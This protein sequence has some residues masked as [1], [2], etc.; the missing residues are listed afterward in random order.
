MYIC[1]YI[2]TYIYI[3]THTFTYMSLY[4]YIFIDMYVYIYMYIYIHIT[5]QRLGHPHKDLK[6]SRLRGGLDASIL[7]A[8]RGSGPAGLWFCGGVGDLRVSTNGEYAQTIR[9][10]FPL[11]TIQLLGYLHLWKL[12][13]DGC[14]MSRFNGFHGWDGP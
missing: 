3:H 12:P 6:P 11:T 4:I 7:T 10:G 9:I 2:Y 1:I 5:P 8:G 13:F 14:L